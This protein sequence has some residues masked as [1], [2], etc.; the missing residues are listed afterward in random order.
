[1]VDTVPEARSR[2]L[3]RLGLP[4][5][6]ADL[7]AVAGLAAV[8]YVA[9]DLSLGLALVQE[10][11]TPLWPPTGIALASFLLLG[12][13]LWPGVA[14][15]A[16][17]VNVPI[18]TSPGAAAATAAGNTLAP[19]VAAT[20]LARMGFR[21]QLDRLRDAVA[22]VF[23]GAL[24]SMTISATVG[25]AVLVAT[26][27]IDAVEVPGAWSVWWVGDAM[28][29]LAFAPFLLT[30][31]P[32]R[33]LRP[34]RWRRAVEAAA[35]AAVL[36][37]TMVGIISAPSSPLFLV[38]PLLGWAAWRFQQVGAA[39]AA[40]VVSVIAT[41]A[42]AERLGP[43]A[44]GT[45]PE[46]MLTLQAFN[47]SVAFTSFFFAA[48]VAE[49]VRDRAALRSWA[50]E[51]ESRVA[52]RTDELTQANERLAA[53]VD[54][55]RRIE[56]ALRRSDAQLE[57]AQELARV[58]S[59]EWDMRTGVVSWSDEMYRIHAY[60]PEGSELTFDRAIELVPPHDRDRVRE[61]VE[62]AIR[63]RQRRVA[64]IEYPIVL[65]DGTTRVLYG[66]ARLTYEDG[67][68]VR[69]VGTVQDITERRA[70]ER[71]HRI[72]E[73]LQRALL[74][75]DLPRS[76]T[77]ELAARYVPAEVGLD[78]GGDWY[79][80][81]ELPSGR[82]AL[83][84]GDVTGHG[85][86]AA[87]VMG[88][89]RLALRA[90]ALEGHPPEVVVSHID[91]LLQRVYPDWM[92]TLLYVDADPAQAVFRIVGA[93]HPPPLVIGPSGKVS[94]VDVPANRPMGFDASTAYA[95]E[96]RPIE[97]GST[98]VLYTDGL[99][100]RPDLPIRDGLDRLR[101]VVAA[102][103]DVGVDS[104]CDRLLDVLV[105]DEV[106]DDVAVLAARLVP[107]PVPFEARV[108]ADPASLFSVRS[109]LSRWLESARIVAGDRHDIVL[110]CSE[111]CANA[112]EHAYGGSADG[113]IVVHAR[114]SD[115]TIELS[116]RDRGRWRVRRDD[117]RGRGLGVIRACMDDV[118]VE[119]G[120]DGTFVRMRRGVKLAEALSV[121]GDG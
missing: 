81:I 56:R 44:H 35:L 108:P 27:S 19:L 24:L 109:S 88:Q 55:R 58:G 79:D 50:A 3:V 52:E 85:L 46:R 33:V 99:I 31:H 89:L 77:F 34:I 23:V 76:T 101:K 115:H 51:L 75:Q 48:L 59:W 15:G 92:A 32:A 40:L 118:S 29:I 10:N 30:F 66:K 64:D 43:F 114:F 9:A 104:L 1:M 105:P 63:R 100:D 7:V 53:E 8:Y 62:R 71:E 11:V 57:E 17:L 21:P 103:G 112:V 39:P 117:D 42:A 37:A 90:Y 47:A 106:S 60:A 38:L 119:S 61:N 80:V 98:L 94:F 12:R 107:V 69:M 13:R 120:A 28:G 68:P 65:H 74:P 102:T 84:I 111:A 96:I 2:G 14:I 67:E 72:A 83:V 22:L 95:T 70:Y 4:R 18:T 86:E 113:E 6:P 78:C 87:T 54:E 82:V 121:A 26:G 41:W 116:V 49:R 45:L 5:R 25:V 93:G 110:A 73:T 16:F 97:P 20:L 91:A 36:L